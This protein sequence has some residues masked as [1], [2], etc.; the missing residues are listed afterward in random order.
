M[1]GQQSQARGGRSRR[2]RRRRGRGA[3][4]DATPT[5]PVSGILAIAK[6][7]HGFLRNPKRNC[8]MQEVDPYVHRNLVVEHGLRQGQMIEGHIGKTL[9]NQGP[10]VATIEKVEGLDVAETKGITILEELTVISPN[11]AFQFVGDEHQDMTMRVIDLVT[12]MGMGQRALIVAPP[13]TGKTVIL[14]KIAQSIT[15]FH[16]DVSLLVC[17]VDERPEEATD[18]KRAVKGEVYASTNDMPAANHVAMTELVT[19]RAKRLCEMGKDVV[20]L[21]DS[22]TR[23]GRAYNIE[24]RG[25]GRTLTGGLDAKVLEKPKA[26]F[27]AA[28]KIEDGG[29][30]TIVATAL[31]DTGSRMDQVIFEEFK[32]TGN[33]ELV[34]DRE[35]ADRR[36]WPAIDV[37]RSGTRK[38]ERLVSEDRLKRMWALRKVLTKMKPLEGMEILLDRLH[39]T[40]SNEEFLALF[41]KT[42]A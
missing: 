16:P 40:P 24:A 27:G 35:L 21:I 23:L 12:P 6:E 18:M 31:V 39:K 41:D 8:Q 15:T 22:L 14:Q 20:V 36:I 34:L 10:M 37:T 2:R 42:M 5:E 30:L 9:R 7:G 33:M 32:G 29:S 3:K 4:F 28:R 26:H 11:Q 1:S 19:S 25:S 17:L 13:R 38:E